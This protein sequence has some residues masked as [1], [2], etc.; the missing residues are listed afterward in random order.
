MAKDPA[1]LWYW[2]DWHGGTITF[3]RHLKG[4]YMDLLHAQFNSGRLSLAQIKTVLGVD[5]GQSWPLLQEKFKKD[6]NDKYYNEKAELVKIKRQKYS[7]SRRNNLKSSHMA[8]H[9]NPHMENEIENENSLKKKED[10]LNNQLW[11]EQFCMAKHIQ[12]AQLEKLQKD[13][14]VSM[15][16]KGDHINS[17]RSYFTSWYEKNNPLK[18]SGDKKMVI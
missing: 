2:N 13:W 16:L 1:T 5:F 12:M 3:S 11:K 18:P 10:F 9:M 4:C 15:D 14:L 17:Y 8:S 7:E 6:D